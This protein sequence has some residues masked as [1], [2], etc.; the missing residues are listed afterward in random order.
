[1]MLRIAKGLIVDDDAVEIGRPY[2]QGN[3]A[4]AKSLRAYWQCG[5]RL[6]ARKKALGHGNWLPWLEREFGWSDSTAL[7]YMQAHQFATDKSVTVTDLSLK[8]ETTL[9]SH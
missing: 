9:G 4:R 7:R 2:A 8:P 3:Q 5:H 6:F 1:M